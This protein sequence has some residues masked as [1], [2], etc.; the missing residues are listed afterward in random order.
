MTSPG[1]GFLRVSLA[2]S[3]CVK[4]IRTMFTVAPGKRES[5]DRE[6]LKG[7]NLYKKREVV[8]S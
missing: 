4:G 5:G 1:S 2:C 3:S 8:F 6:E 7:L